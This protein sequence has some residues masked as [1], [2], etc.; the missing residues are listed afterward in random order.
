MI[1]RNW[2]LLAVVLCGVSAIICAVR[3]DRAWMIVNAIFMG[4]NLYYYL[5]D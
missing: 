3:D 4:S 2:H 5:K 1:N